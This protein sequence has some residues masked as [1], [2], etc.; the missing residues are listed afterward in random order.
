MIGIARTKDLAMRSRRLPGQDA[1]QWG[2]AVECV[3]D[4]KLEEATD[5]LV[6]ELRGFSPLA[7]RTLKSVINSSQN[8]S[9]QVAIAHEGEAYG[10]LRSS[11]DFREGVHSFQEKRR[12]NFTGK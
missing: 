2:I 11:D 3:A 5:S 1:Y 7:Q 9:L 8:T 6:E 4:D 10:R 12:P